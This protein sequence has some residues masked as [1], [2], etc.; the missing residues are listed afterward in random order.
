M[1]LLNRYR[2][3][4][5][6]NLKRLIDYTDW[7]EE[8][9]VIVT[10]DVTIS[11]T[12]DTPLVVDSALIDD[13]GKKFAYYTSGGEDGTDYTITFALATNAAQVREDEVEIDVEEI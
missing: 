11:P 12:T 8:D 2:Q 5:G 10:V 7:L 6:E 13:E 4:P 3:Q 9:E 1:A